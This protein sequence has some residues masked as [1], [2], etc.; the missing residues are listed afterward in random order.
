MKIEIKSFDDQAA[1][2]FDED[3]V[4]R[5]GLKIGQTVTLDFDDEGATLTAPESNY[6]IRLER[7]QA[8][9]RRYIKTFEALAK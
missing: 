1:L 3:V 7:G 5:L 6:Q 9:V 2:V 4:E 8:F